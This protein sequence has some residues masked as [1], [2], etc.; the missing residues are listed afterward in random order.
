MS[1]LERGQR[2]RPFLR[3]LS[4]GSDEMPFLDHLEELRWRIIWSGVALLVGS[5]LGIFLV[6]Q[7]GVLGLLTAPVAPYIEGGRLAYLSPT[8]PFVVTLKVGFFIGLLVSLPILAYHFWAFIDPA[9]LKRERGV[10]YP[11]LAASVLLFLLGTYLAFVQVMPLGLRFLLGFQ[12]ETLWPVL[13]IKEYLSFA[14]RLSLAFGL[15]SELPLIIYVLSKLG[16]VSPSF[17]RAKRPHVIVGIA[18]ISAL[19]TPPDVVTMVVMLLPL[20]LLYELSIWISVLVI[21]RR[22][23]SQ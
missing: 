10:L 8:E 3:R 4:R 14:I 7:T 6:Q 19:L 22:Q 21:R 18:V 1:T 13:T 2:A 15:I 12:T 20:Y 17:L 5:G 16:L 23:A 9:L 11:A